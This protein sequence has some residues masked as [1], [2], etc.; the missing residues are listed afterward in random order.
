MDGKRILTSLATVIKKYI[1]LT[2][3]KGEVAVSLFPQQS[4]ENAGAKQGAQ[5]SFT[6]HPSQ[7]PPTHE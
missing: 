1:L 5:N 4:R 7:S 3:N 2:V 6:F